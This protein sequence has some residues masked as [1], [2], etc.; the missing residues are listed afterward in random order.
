QGCRIAIAPGLACRNP[1]GTPDILR[2]EETQIL[3]YLSLSPENREIHLL[4]L[5][6]THT[7]WVIVKKG[8]VDTFLTS[9]QG[10]LFDMLEKHSVL[11]PRES[12]PAPTAQ[13]TPDAE[14][15][16]YFDAGVALTLKT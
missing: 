13:A 7:K 11:L 9:M 16:S 8:Y 10:E 5:P 2:G 6:G 1:L 3:G 4:C 14:L 15:K 12:G